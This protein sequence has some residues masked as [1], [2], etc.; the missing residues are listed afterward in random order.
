MIPGD[1][2]IPVNR[3]NYHLGIYKYTVN[4]LV[5]MFSFPRVINCLHWSCQIPWMH[6]RSGLNI[7]YNDSR[8]R[9][10]FI[11]L[12]VCCAILN[13]PPQ[14][15]V[16][17]KDEV[18]PNKFSNAVQYLSVLL[19]KQYVYLRI[20][21]N[22]RLNSS[23]CRLLRLSLVLELNLHHTPADWLSSGG[24]WSRARM[25]APVRL[26]R[27]RRVALLGRQKWLVVHGIG[28]DVWG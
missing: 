23:P 19:R 9:F 2:Y 14:R 11:N 10:A 22:V 21:W 17:S 3:N 7:R 5:E 26:A 4:V 16:I 13:I 6:R 8:P 24:P 20:V 18:V 15:N 28:A 12:P 1:P 27:L 25:P